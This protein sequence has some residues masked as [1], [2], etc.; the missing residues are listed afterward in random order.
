MPG[1]NVSYVASN[2]AKPGFGGN[3]PINY[4]TACRTS[5]TALGVRLCFL[6][7]RTYSPQGASQW[8]A[9]TSVHEHIRSI[10]GKRK[11]RG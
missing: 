10:E 3:V 2:W 7:K 8:K 4:F 5:W 11:W 1:S 9:F 6:C